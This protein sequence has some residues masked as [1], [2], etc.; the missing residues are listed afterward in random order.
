[1]FIVVLPLFQG[2]TFLIYNSSLCTDNPVLAEL[3]VSADYS[4]ECQWDGGSTSNAA[5]V[6]L[7][8]LTGVAMVI[9]GCPKRPPR[10]PPETQAVTYQRTTNPDGTATVAQVGVVKGTAVPAPAPAATEEMPL[11]AED[12]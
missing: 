1:V 4:Q 10:P 5:S 6:A 8:F 11:K 12:A 3:G 7:W 2:L 9:V